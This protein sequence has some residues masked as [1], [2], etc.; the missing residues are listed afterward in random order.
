[1][2]EHILLLV[3]PPKHFDARHGQ[4]E[5]PICPA[6]LRRNARRS[7]HS[8]ER[9]CSRPPLHE[10]SSS[11]GSPAVIPSSPGER[12]RL[13]GWL[14]SICRPTSLRGHGTLQLKG[15][16]GSWGSTI[17]TTEMVVMEGVP[18]ACLYAL[19][20]NVPKSTVSARH[21][22]RVQMYCFQIVIDTS[23][24]AWPIICL[25]AVSRCELK[26]W[27]LGHLP[28][29]WNGSPDGSMRKGS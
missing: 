27:E 1:M 16:V 11:E 29:E 7:F 23:H 17:S 25:A 3:P 26:P 12:G 6:H 21:T 9:R 5:S 14:P 18:S 20:K 15:W 4:R 8:E 28:S 24:C 10:G 2:F 13:R 22:L 19:P